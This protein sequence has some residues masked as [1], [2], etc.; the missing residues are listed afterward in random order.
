[1]G[2]RGGMVPGP[3]LAGLA[4][5]AFATRAAAQEESAVPPCTGEG[6]EAA[7]CRAAYD[8]APVL[9]PGSVPPLAGG[10]ALTPRVWI[11]VDETGAVRHAQVA[12]PTR[13]DWDMAARDRALHF[14]FTPAALAGKPVAA[15]ILVPVRAVP[16]PAS[17][18]DVSM[19]VPLSA[20]A[21]FAD[22]VV[23]DRPSL[24]T[25]FHYTA[26]GFGI[27][28]F[29][30]PHQALTPRGEVENTLALL[31]QGAVRGGPDS[32]AVLRAGAQ[33]L[34]PSRRFRDVRFNG[35][36]AL[37]RATAEG[38]P[39]ESY[40][41]VFPAGGQDLEIRATYPLGVHGRAQVAEFV[42]QLLSSRASRMKGCPR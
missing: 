26:R 11:Y 40:M 22:S 14:R 9:D 2:R 1:M 6:R 18:A 30:H 21:Q 3:R 31:R 41:A 16:P 23:L 34:R 12:Q 15:W 35:Y 28:L 38:I 32:V 17:C 42:Q 25:R 13:H 29:V 37:F 33:R 4:L 36:S 27:D 8:S 19:S 24:G 39:V 20:G 5:L 7:P 10:G